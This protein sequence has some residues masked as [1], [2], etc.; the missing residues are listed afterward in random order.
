[1]YTV[2]LMTS[3]RLRIHSNSD[4]VFKTEDTAVQIN[5]DDIFKTDIH[6]NSDDIFKTDVQSNFD[7]VFNNKDTQ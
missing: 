7:D 5:S 4:D 3:L 6:S 1:M 2:I